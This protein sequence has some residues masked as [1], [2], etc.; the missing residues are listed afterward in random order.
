MTQETRSLSIID[1]TKSFPNG[2][3]EL[4]LFEPV[5]LDIERGTSCSITGE[6]G[7]GKSTFLQIAAGLEKPTAGKVC[8]YDSEGNPVDVFSLS[9]SRISAL[10][11]RMVGFIFQHNFL[12]EDFSPL[13]NIM[14]PCLIGGMNRTDAAKRATELLERFSLGYLAHRKVTTL[15][16]GEKQRVAVCRA[17]SNNPALIFADEPTGALDQDNSALVQSML[18]E[19]VDQ[20]GCSLLLVTHSPEFARCCTVQYRINDRKLSRV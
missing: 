13:E 15:S 14:I 5:S 19:L 20:Q 12:L 4:L 9:D 18:T 2:D 8:W 16:G 1:V 10:R 11:N 6:S 17:V 7:S 3:R